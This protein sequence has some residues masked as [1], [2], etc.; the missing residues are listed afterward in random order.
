MVAVTRDVLF[1]QNH[2][3]HK[4]SYVSLTLKKAS[5]AKKSANKF[6]WINI[7]YGVKIHDI[8][9]LCLFYASVQLKLSFKQMI[10]DV[11]CDSEPL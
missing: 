1:S 5:L 3:F 7:A 11:E 8:L 6:L 9:L 4:K 2:C 10:T